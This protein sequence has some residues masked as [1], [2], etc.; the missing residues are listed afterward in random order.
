MKNCT[1]C[2]LEKTLSSFYFK[3]RTAGKL[4]SQCKDCYTVKRKMF[5][6]EHYLKY[7]DAYRKRARERKA[8]IKKQRQDQL[9]EYLAGRGC[10][11][12]EV[13]NILVLDFDHIDSRTKK[14][15][16]A[17][18]INEGYAWEE[19]L[20]EIKKCRILC[21]NCHRI[22]T[23]EQFGW[24]KWRRGRVVRQNSAKVLTP[25][26]SRSVPPVT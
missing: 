6:E 26:R 14:F 9:I 2:G 5:M 16:I 22:R 25:V 1:V 15:S 10:E 7:G 23:A 20:R 18:A 19:I 3:N 17:R 8:L 12:C 4:H 11:I 24:R 13:D 21:S